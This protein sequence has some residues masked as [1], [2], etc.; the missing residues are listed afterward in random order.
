MRVLLLLLLLLPVGAARAQGGIHRCMGADGIPVFT[1]RVCT[2]VNAKPVLEA[3]AK[4][5]NAHI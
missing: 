3:P 1:D 4:N 2:D 5:A